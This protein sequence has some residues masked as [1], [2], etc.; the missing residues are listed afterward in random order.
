V[1]CFVCRLVGLNS[2]RMLYCS[3][4]KRALSKR[5]SHRIIGPDSQFGVRRQGTPRRRFSLRIENKAASRSTLPPHS[6]EHQVRIT[7]RQ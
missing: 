6:K 4:S 5:R 1:L 7:H 2:I 3:Y